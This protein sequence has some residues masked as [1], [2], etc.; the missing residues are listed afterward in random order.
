MKLSIYKIATVHSRIEP[1]LKEVAENIFHKLEL[2]TSKTI[3][4]FYRQVVLN[5]GLPFNV[6]ISNKKTLEAIKELENGEVRNLKGLRT[7][8]KFWSFRIILSV[9]A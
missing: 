5:K 6:K 1:Q 7:L 3:E 2:S 9:K 4:V 8:K